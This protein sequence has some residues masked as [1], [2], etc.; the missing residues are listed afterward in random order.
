MP[1][2]TLNPEQWR[3]IEELY[4]AALDHRPESRETFLF[5]ACNGDE[6]LRRE[7]ESLLAT[8]GEGAIVDHAALELAA[9]LL[10]DGAP[11]PAGTRLGPY[12]LEKLPGTGGGGGGCQW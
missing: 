9:E 12:C 2:A 3:R 1:K 6:S 5:G 4:Y 8:D 10:D 7:V 11:L